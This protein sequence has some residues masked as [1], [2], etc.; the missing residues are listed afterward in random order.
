MCTS[1]TSNA[2]D[3][4]TAVRGWLNAVHAGIDAKVIAAKI[5]TIVRP[6]ES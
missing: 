3:A 6:L 1:A 2:G 5:L 4:G